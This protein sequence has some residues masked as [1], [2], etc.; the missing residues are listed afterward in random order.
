MR[1]GNTALKPIASKSNVNKI[2][3]WMREETR[4]KGGDPPQWSDAFPTK[5]EVSEKQEGTKE[6][7]E[8]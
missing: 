6:R 4:M 1:E 3:V 7:A 5:Q 2:N 8:R